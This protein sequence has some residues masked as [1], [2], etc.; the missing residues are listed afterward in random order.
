M[1]FEIEIRVIAGIYLYVNLREK[2]ENSLGNGVYLHGRST[3]IPL[4]RR[5]WAQSSEL[6]ETL[7]AFWFKVTRRDN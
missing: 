7:L 3:R 5:M 6:F 2:L 1:P 4:H